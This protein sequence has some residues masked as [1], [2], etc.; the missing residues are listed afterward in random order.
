MCNAICSGWMLIAPLNLKIHFRFLPPELLLRTDISD[1]PLES[2]KCNPLHNTTQSYECFFKNLQDVTHFRFLP[3]GYRTYKVYSVQLITNN[4][5]WV[6]MFS[7]RK[8]FR[9]DCTGLRALQCGT[10]QTIHVAVAT[11]VKLLAH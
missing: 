6:E 9:L 5:E 7:L 1:S 10:Q 11:K 4:S 2:T 3:L 8:N